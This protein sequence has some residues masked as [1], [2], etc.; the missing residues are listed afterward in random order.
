MR[1]WSEWMSL[2]HGCAASAAM[3]GEKRIAELEAALR[4]VH[5]QSASSLVFNNPKYR[6]EKHGT[7]EN[8][9]VSSIGPAA[10][11]WCMLCALEKLDELGVCRAQ[12]L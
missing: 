11:Y 5:A 12:K 3:D 6:C 4:E 1:T 10:T 8:V 9:I 2:P 7:V